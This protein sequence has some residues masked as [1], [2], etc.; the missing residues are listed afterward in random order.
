MVP[1]N[2]HKQV[3]MLVVEAYQM[4]ILGKNLGSVIMEGVK[5]VINVMVLAL[6]NEF[7]EIQREAKYFLNNIWH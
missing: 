6:E 4:F 5:Q 2:I 1:W 3:A 7:S